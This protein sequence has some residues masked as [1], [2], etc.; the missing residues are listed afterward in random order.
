M[1]VPARLWRSWPVSHF[2]R[3]LTLVS[4]R[5]R[6]GTGVLIYIIGWSL[7][8]LGILA[9]GGQAFSL[10]QDRNRP[11]GR[12]SHGRTP[13][14]KMPEEWQRLRLTVSTT[15]ILPIILISRT[16][17]ASA[18]WQVPARGLVVLA[19]AI[20]LIWE[21]R[22]WRRITDPADRRRAL[23]EARWFF[24][25]PLLQVLWLIHIWDNGTGRTVVLIA[26]IV[27]MAGPDVESWIR[28]RLV[29]RASGSPP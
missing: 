27:L 13:P 24:I 8:G 23:N 11:V 15:L 1:R 6:W 14:E 4:H 12:H 10:M 5:L 26:A 22:S 20:L 21:I 3:V 17:E 29:H 25:P 28:G 2:R 16:A 7:F 19:T 9:V 18:S